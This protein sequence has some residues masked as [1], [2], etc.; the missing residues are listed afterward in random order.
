MLTL[1]E[2]YMIIKVAEDDEEVLEFYIF[3]I[4]LY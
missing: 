4:I 1:G 2:T 3:S